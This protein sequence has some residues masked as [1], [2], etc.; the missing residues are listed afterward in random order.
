M[1][2]GSGNCGTCLKAWSANHANGLSTPEDRESAEEN[3]SWLLSNSYQ[4]SIEASLKDSEET[5]QTKPVLACLGDTES[6]A[7]SL[8]RTILNLEQF[9]EFT[10]DVP[11]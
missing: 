5:I 6:G 8:E 10:E 1:I 11:E 2:S 4:V 7:E 9:N 3:L